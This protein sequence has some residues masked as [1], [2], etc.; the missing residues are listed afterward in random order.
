M[1]IGNLTLP[2]L[3]LLA[4]M[5][6]VTELPFRQLCLEQGAAMVFTEMVSVN[7]LHHA[8]DRGALLRARGEEG[9]T[10][11]QIFGRDP[12][13]MAAMAARYGEGFDAI[14]INMG[15]PMPKIIKSGQGS[16]LMLEPDVAA[17]IVR[18]VRAAVP[19][20]VMVKIRAGWCADQI[21][22][23]DF[24]RALED[25][26]A[27]AVTVHARTREQLYA[28][29]ADWALIGRVKAAL[30]IPVIGNGDV[31]GGPAA[32][33]M[34]DETGCDAVMVG[35][36]AR[37]D[38]WIFRRINH[39][40]ATGEELPPPGVEER[41]AMALRHSR[42]MAR[43]Q[44]ESQGIVKMRKHMAWY[45]RGLPQAAACRRRLMQ[46]RTLRDLERELTALIPTV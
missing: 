38:P 24:A 41:V 40:L 8:P 28:G 5:A 35:R 14:D 10:G 25:A 29:R 22:A 43:E 30:S 32:R 15:C 4:P 12:A 33:R 17:A 7:G 11:L 31:D 20:P 1:R 9:L 21:N 26:G 3:A 23:V 2:G 13:L 19:Q 34:M 16:A 6:G 39:Y 27:D 44:G 36:A 46:A 37:G 18:A 45:L 42:M